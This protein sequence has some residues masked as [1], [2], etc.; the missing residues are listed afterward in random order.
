MVEE[1]EGGDGGMVQRLGVTLTDQEDC[2]SGSGRVRVVQWTGQGA[3]LG[4]PT[5]Q[6]KRTE[7]TR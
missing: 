7:P 4:P 6:R 3:R 5:Q 1:E 2:T